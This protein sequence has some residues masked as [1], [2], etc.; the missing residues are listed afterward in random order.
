MTDSGEIL[1]AYSNFTIEE[2]EL[3]FDLQL[4]AVS[5]LPEIEPIAPSDILNRYLDRGLTLA[6]R[7]VSEKARSEFIIAPIFLELETLLVDRISIF[8]GEDFTVDRSIG[9][10]G[11]CDFLIARSPAQLIIKAP[12]IAVVEAKKGVLRDGWGQCIAELVAAQKFN[13]QRHQEIPYTYGIVTSG[14]LWQ[15]IRLSGQTVSIEPTEIPLH[16]LDR[17]LGILAWLA[18]N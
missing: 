14:L 13:L 5:F 4:Q 11:I 17:L 1:M 15:F 10:S 3:R 8:S 9:L 6:K 16:P 7:N 18:Q 2:V 12:V